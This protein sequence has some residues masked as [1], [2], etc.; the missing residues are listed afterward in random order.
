MSL[1]CDVEKRNDKMKRIITYTSA[2]THLY[3][4]V[5]LDQVVEIYNQQNKTPLNLQKAKLTIRENE[6]ELKKHFVYFHGEYAV[7]ES[8]L[9]EGTFDELLLNQQTKPFYIP[10]QKELMKY[11]DEFYLEETKEYKALKKYLTTAVFKRDAF[12]AEMLIEDIEGY[13]KYGFSLEAILKEFERRDVTFE[14]QKQANEVIQLIMELANNTRLRENNGF[15]PNELFNQYEKSQLQPLPN[16]DFKPD[17][18]KIGRNDPCPCRSGKKY[19]KCCMN[20][21]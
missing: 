2:L 11:A 16:S 3:D 9:E 17:A 15:T 5:H 18:K 13:C 21:V 12:K 20:K 8:V 1:N 4:L 14:S 6:E 19:K 7:H 10:E